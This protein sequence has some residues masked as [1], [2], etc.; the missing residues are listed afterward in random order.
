MK[1]SSPNINVKQLKKLVSESVA[2]SKRFRCS[3]NTAI[4]KIIR[5]G[6]AIPQRNSARPKLSND[7][8]FKKANNIGSTSLIRLLLME[9][10]GLKL[11]LRT[12]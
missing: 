11:Y 8:W 10:G 5:G 9:S 7:D 2:R 4:S 12:R 3:S 6:A 1:I